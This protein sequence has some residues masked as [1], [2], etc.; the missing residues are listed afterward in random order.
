MLEPSPQLDQ[1]SIDL[2]PIHDVPL[3]ESQ[4]NELIRLPVE[5]KLF[6]LLGDQEIRL[7]SGPLCLLKPV[8]VRLSSPK[9]DDSRRRTDSENDSDEIKEALVILQVG[10]ATFPIHRHTPFGTTAACPFSYLF[11]P[12]IPGLPSGYIKLVLP[13]RPIDAFPLINEPGLTPSR[14]SESD[15]LEPPPEL[16]ALRNSFEQVL[17]DMNILQ[18]QSLLVTADEM[19][20]ALIE[21]SRLLV[22]RW[23]SAIGSPRSPEKEP[24][25]TQN[26]PAEEQSNVLKG[27]DALEHAT[28]T[29]SSYS[30]RFASTLDRWSMRFGKQLSERL[31]PTS[32]DSISKEA[33][34]TSAPGSLSLGVVSE[35]GSKLQSGITES[36]KILGSGI[37]DKVSEL[38]K[39][40][41]APNLLT[42]LGHSVQNIGSTVGNTF[43][44]TSPVNHATR[45]GMGAAS[46][47]PEEEEEAKSNKKH[48]ISNEIQPAFVVE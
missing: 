27:A 36:T 25:E 30:G 7:A 31:A 42:R 3:S 44:A 13:S 14:P 22:N 37:V 38:P 6:H 35:A 46:S 32:P 29:F 24:S 33:N 4:E 19:S 43:L 15:D 45:V 11:K 20:R 10:L 17:V 16:I 18:D 12:D 34:Q 28:S 41:I 8:P 39:P 48:P 21:R 1:Q 26:D 23:V 47:N 40:G 5:C 9:S 2:E